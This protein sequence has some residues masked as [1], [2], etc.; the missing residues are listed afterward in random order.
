MAVGFILS[1]R[2]DRWILVPTEYSWPVGMDRVCANPCIA[3]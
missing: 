2:R 1:K 3:R